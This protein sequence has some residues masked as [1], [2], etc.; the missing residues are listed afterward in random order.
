MADQWFKHTFS[1][2]CLMKKMTKFYISRDRY[3]PAWACNPCIFFIYPN[4]LS[5]HKGPAQ[6]LFGDRWG[7]HVS[8]PQHLKDHYRPTKKDKLLF[9]QKQVSLT[10]VFMLM[11]HWNQFCFSPSAKAAHHMSS[12]GSL[13]SIFSVN[14]AQLCVRNCS[15]KT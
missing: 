11:C 10:V 3:W 2:L 8:K 7:E 4:F 6:N 14:G 5:T 15:L 9:K 12:S 13:F 1:P